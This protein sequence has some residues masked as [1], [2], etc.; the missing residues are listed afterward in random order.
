MADVVVKRQALATSN[1]CRESE[2]ILLVVNE[3]VGEL[4]RGQ[5]RFRDVN[6]KRARLLAPLA[7]SPTPPSHFE[8][9]P[10]R[11]PEDKVKTCF[12]RKY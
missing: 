9:Y 6:R 3:C 10:C 12:C 1:D 5:S 2:A 11:R 4:S 8:F 7:T